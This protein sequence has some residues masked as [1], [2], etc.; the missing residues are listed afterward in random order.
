MNRTR[1]LLTICVIALTLSACTKSLEA[2]REEA[3]VKILKPL[4]KDPDSLI[5]ECATQETVNVNFD[6]ELDYFECQ[7]RAKNSFGAYNGNKL[8][9]F[10]FRRDSAWPVEAKYFDHDWRNMNPAPGRK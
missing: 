6:Q 8:A 3:A 1:Q 9:G 4:M 2:Q 5:V 10:T 7:Y